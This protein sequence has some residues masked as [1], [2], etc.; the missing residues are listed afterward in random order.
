MHP[1][2]PYQVLVTDIYMPLNDGLEAI[3][4]FRRDTRGSASS[5]CPRGGSRRGTAIS[6]SRPEIGADATLAKP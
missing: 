6:A 3:Q 1:A 4:A 5:P 2:R